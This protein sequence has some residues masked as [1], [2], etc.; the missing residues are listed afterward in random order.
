M[1]AFA[2]SPWSAQRSARQS[3]CPC[4][5]C[6]SRPRAVACQS[7]PPSPHS[8]R[9]SARPWRAQGGGHFRGFLAFIGRGPLFVHPSASRP[10]AAAVGART[11]CTSG[12]TFALDLS[13]SP[14]SGCEERRPQGAVSR[15]SAS[16]GGGGG[17]GVIV[18]IAGRAGAPWAPLS[19]VL[20]SASASRSSGGAP[21]SQA[22]E[23][24]RASG[25]RGAAAGSERE[26]YGSSPPLCAPA[27]PPGV[28]DPVERRAC[29]SL[30]PGSV[31]DHRC[32]PLAVARG[33]REPTELSTHS[34]APCR[35]RDPSG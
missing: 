14:R 7:R 22:S 5:I 30:P 17:V 3:A 1:L 19:G 8:R 24:T 33:L 32:T 25:G 2:A 9:P 12:A 26:S 6:R 18:V 28:S 29:D 10:N 21:R 27:F 35:R 20:S 11:G 15:E 4:V 13:A 34:Q 23:R 31:R 16:V